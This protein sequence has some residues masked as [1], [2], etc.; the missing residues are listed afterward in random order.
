MNPLI[1]VCVPVYNAEPYIRTCVES[2]L[3]QSFRDFEI[4]LVDDGS[5][6]N[7]LAI[8]QSL[9]SSSSII[10]VIHTSNKGDTAARGTAVEHSTGSWITFVDSDDSLPNYALSRL[11]EGFE[12]DS[13]IIVGFSF[14]S[15]Y[16]PYSMSIETWRKK[17]IRS[18][19]IYCSPWARLFK[20]SLLTKEVFSLSTSIRTG[21]DM[22]MNIKIAFNTDKDV[23]IINSKVYN[24]V[25]RPNSLSR[26]AIWSINKIQDLY[27]EVFHS[28]PTGKIQHY[29]PQLIEN[30]LI[31][32]KN[33]CLS[34]NKREPIIDTVF[35]KRL[36]QDI[37]ES[38]YRL[39]FLQRLSIFHPDSIITASLFKA[40]NK[41]R[42]GIE[43]I[44]RKIK[45]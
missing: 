33:R 21:T 22:P 45:L 38:N 4:V 41:L 27:E 36:K 43:F 37:S 34:N 23:Y 5:T 17:L 18:D 1:S 12:K 20:R 6:D 14:E 42:I 11:A 3:H 32:L 15:G 19:V 35:I 31:S 8:C 24:Y 16:P 40:Q 7:S 30:R 39:S 44:R 9:A 10:T 25:P 28:I 29:M 2:I 26:S 13:D